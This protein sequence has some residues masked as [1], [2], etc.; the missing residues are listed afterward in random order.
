[1]YISGKQ[2]HQTRNANDSDPLET[3][4]KLSYFFQSFQCCQAACKGKGAIPKTETSM[5][6]NLENTGC[7]NMCVLLTAIATP[8]F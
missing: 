6:K 1:M 8:E 2:F 7:G 3:S 4:P 5:I